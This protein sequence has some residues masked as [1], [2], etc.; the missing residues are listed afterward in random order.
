MIALKPSDQIAEAFKALLH[1]G[2][3]LLGGSYWVP[4]RCGK[5]DS[6]VTDANL[7]SMLAEPFSPGE[8][9]VLGAMGVYIYMYTLGCF[10]S[11]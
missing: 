11:Q 1:G 3:W 9:S 6:G 5:C 2:P 4:D 10:P 7:E 8:S